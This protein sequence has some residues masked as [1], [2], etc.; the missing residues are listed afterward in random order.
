MFQMLASINKLS[1][2]QIVH[3]LHRF[4]SLEFMFLA[5]FLSERT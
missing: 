5:I 3:F 2:L 4:N 1:N